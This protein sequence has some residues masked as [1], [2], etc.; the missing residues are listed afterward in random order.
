M[1][2]VLALGGAGCQT[3]EDN[4]AGDNQGGGQNINQDINGAGGETGSEESVTPE[5][6]GESAPAGDV[7]FVSY[8]NKSMNYTID[9]PEKWYW[10]HYIQK[11]IGET[12]AGVIDYF[13]TDSS[14]LPRLESEYLGMIVIEVSDKSVE[15]INGDVSDLTVSDATVA[16]ISA[17]KYEG[18]RD[19]EIVKNQKVVIYT[20]EKDGRTF[21]AIYKKSNSTSEREAVFEHLVSSLS[22]NK[23][24]RQ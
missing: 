2:S 21:R 11:E 19:N 6:D 23:Q 8:V 20:F 7:S 15:E 4:S 14:P 18:I 24:K 12:H 5:E 16:G 3:A 17:K 10:R 13:I 22:F 1:I 9:R